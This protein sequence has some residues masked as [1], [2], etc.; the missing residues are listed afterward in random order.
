M[1]PLVTLLVVAGSI[2]F[3]TPF[4]VCDPCPN[5][6]GAAQ[7]AGEMGIPAE[8]SV[9]PFGSP[10]T[11]SAGAAPWYQNS[12]VS[13]SEEVGATTGPDPYQVWGG[14]LT[15]GG[16]ADAQVVRVT[17]DGLNAGVCD[18]APQVG[19]CTWVPLTRLP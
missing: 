18:G 2:G 9:G 16:Y 15:V 12:F 8:I 6:L 14:R 7:P 11:I 1:L 4:A 5:P 10:S 13:A 17:N 19:G 3:P